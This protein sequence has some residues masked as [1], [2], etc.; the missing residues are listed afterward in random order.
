M[1]KARFHKKGPSFCDLYHFE[2][3]T[4][5]VMC[6]VHGGK[7]LSSTPSCNIFPF[8]GLR[9]PPLI[10]MCWHGVRFDLSCIL[11]KGALHSSHLQHAN[12]LCSNK[13]RKTVK[14]AIV[15]KEENKLSRM[16]CDFYIWC[17]S[18]Y[19][20]EDSSIRRARFLD[21]LVF[22]FFSIFVQQHL[23][24]FILPLAPFANRL[25]SECYCMIIF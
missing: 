1:F 7:D 6:T 11:G 16:I 3:L 24:I 13:V 25:K 22:I 18:S 12:R 23:Q 19:S 2:V 4:T 5:L 10:L 20:A 17:S 15:L 8:L 9:T 14:I 21:S